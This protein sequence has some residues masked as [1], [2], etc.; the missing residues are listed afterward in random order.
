[1]VVQQSKQG[2]ASSGREAVADCEARTIEKWKEDEMVEGGVDGGVED[3]MSI[4]FG[5]SH[6]QLQ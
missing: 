5:C 3:M 2:P 4:K 1:M 6:V